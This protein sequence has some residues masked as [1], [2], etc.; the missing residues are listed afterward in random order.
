MTRRDDLAGINHLVHSDTT[1][2]FPEL[3][4]MFTIPGKVSDKVPRHYAI[5]SKWV[6]GHTR[7]TASLGLQESFQS[8]AKLPTDFAWECRCTLDGDDPMDT[9]FSLRRG[10]QLY[11]VLRFGEWAQE[12]IFPDVPLGYTN[13]IPRRRPCS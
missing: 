11:P 7:L 9:M 12:P 2:L 13:L 4:T 10:H 5:R 6:L 1:T 3:Q 8:L